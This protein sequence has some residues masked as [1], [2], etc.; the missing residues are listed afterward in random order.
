MPA[1]SGRI[2]LPLCKTRIK[3]IDIIYHKQASRDR[4]LCNRLENAEKEPSINN[5]MLFEVRERSGWRTI[6]PII[7]VEVQH[8]G[9]NL[10]LTSQ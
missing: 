8:A 4:L 9:S 6:L 7:Q 3:A 2:M 10:A 1:T 5:H